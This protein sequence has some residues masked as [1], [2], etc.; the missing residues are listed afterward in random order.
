MNER[1]NPANA[2]SLRFLNQGAYTAGGNVQNAYLELRRSFAGQ[3][4]AYGTYG[5]G[6]PLMGELGDHAHDHHHTQEGETTLVGRAVE[7]ANSYPLQI[8]AVDE[9]FRELG[10]KPQPALSTFAGIVGQATRRAADSVANVITHSV[11]AGPSATAIAAL[12]NDAW[13][14][15]LTAPWE[16][17]S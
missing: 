15:L 5:V 7:L 16:G 17:R 4:Q 11:G 10:R 6:Q 1:M 12:T 14:T 3:R 13:D 8:P 2:G 9:V